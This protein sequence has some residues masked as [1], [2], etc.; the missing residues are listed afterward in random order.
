MGWSKLQN[1]IRLTK[2][3]ECTAV[4]EG[5]VANSEP[6]VAPGGMYLGLVL[7]SALSAWASSL[8]LSCLREVEGLEVQPLLFCLF[9]QGGLARSVSWAGLLK[10]GGADPVHAG[11]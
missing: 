7:G 1:L 6:S 11:L 3:R 9:S 5:N 10:L 8:E 2:Q 4:T